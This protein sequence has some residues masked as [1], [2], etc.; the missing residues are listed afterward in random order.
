[1]APRIVG[2]ALGDPNGIGPEVCVKA[3]ISAYRHAG[4]R[5][6]LFG[7]D[8][9]LAHYL[10]LLGLS[11]ADAA[12]LELRHVGALAERDWQ[13]GQ[14]S[15]AA[16][17]ATL[18]YLRAAVDAMRAGELTA[19]GAGPHSE[20]AVNAAGIRFSGYG[21]YLAQIT[22]TPAD[23]VFLMLLAGDL[24][25][26]HVTLHERL[27]DAIGRID[28]RLVEIC[29]TAA[30][31]AAQRLGM[32][33][34]SIGVL[35]INPH[36]GENGLFGPEDERI[37]RP[38]V[39]RLRDLGWP[40]DGPLAADLALSQRRH[41]VYVAMYHDQGHI[42]AKM[43]SP[44]GATALVAGLP[45]AFASVGHGAA[46][47]IAGSGHADASALIETVLLLGARG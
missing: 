44:K 12:G 37:T 30:H 34:P 16:G 15:P 22:D 8:Y 35:G 47:D 20:T 10:R 25:I 9:I 32:D 33:A 27:A 23:R 14:V 1:M 6:V 39:Q 11:A 43:L 24:R 42:P 19:V 28:E 21:G 40:V 26:I 5:C 31:K 17:V 7:E 46:F 41:T 45:F 18:T 29:C 38:A 4:V 36:A 3:A 13:P 2:L